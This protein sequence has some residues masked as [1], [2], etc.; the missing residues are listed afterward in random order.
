MGIFT[1]S[2]MGTEIFPLSPKQEKLYHAV[3][4]DGPI[5][6]YDGD[7]DESFVDDIKTYMAQILVSQRPNNQRKTNFLVRWDNDFDEDWAQKFPYASHRIFERNPR[8]I[9]L[10]SEEQSAAT[11]SLSPNLYV[12]RQV[13]YFLSLFSL[14]W[15][16]IIIIS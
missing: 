15:L 10:T 5:N 8:R 16:I 1:P 6:H 3:A 7:T 2:L 12:E 14:S 4:T 11:F 9:Q 13:N